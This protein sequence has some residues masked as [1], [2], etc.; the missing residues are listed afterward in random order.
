MAGASP[1]EKILATPLEL[2]GQS[3]KLKSICFILHTGYEAKSHLAK[4][5]FGFGYQN[6]VSMFL[7]I[8]RKYYISR[9]YAF[10]K[11][12]QELFVKIK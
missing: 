1:P 6:I 9:E 7:L 4:R 12:A 2:E 3:L 11:N 5:I 10:V 8:P